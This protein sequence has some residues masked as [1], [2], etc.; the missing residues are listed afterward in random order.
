VQDLVSPPYQLGQDLNLRAAGHALREEEK[1]GGSTACWQSRVD[2]GTRQWPWQGVG[3]AVGADERGGGRDA[4]RFPN[5][6][7]WIVRLE[8]LFELIPNFLSA[9]ADHSD[10]DLLDRA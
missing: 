4:L 2:H 10:E 7:K 9:A 6:L 8:P 3:E 1:H 5:H